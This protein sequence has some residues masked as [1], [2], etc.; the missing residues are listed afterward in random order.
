[1]RKSVELPELFEVS[2]HVEIFRAA[3][4]RRMR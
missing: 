1:M 4:G 2:F 3:T